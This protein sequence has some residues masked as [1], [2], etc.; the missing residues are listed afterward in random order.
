M[1]SWNPWH[2]CTKISAGCANCYVYRSD[3]NHGRDP[4]AVRKNASFTL[5]V[6]KKRSGAYRLQPDGD[7]V[8]TC[9]TSDFFHPAADEWRKEAWRFMQ[10]RR[11]LEFLIIT[12]RVNRFFV[13]LPE[14]WEEGYENVTV[15]GTCENQE[16]ADFRLPI[17]ASLPIRRKIII[18]EPL[19]GAIDLRRYLAIRE[20]GG[21]PMIRELVCGGE[22][23]NDARI[24]D[25]GWI[26]SLR[27]QCLA[28]GVPF[29]FRQ[30]GAL[31]RKDGRLYR[32]PRRLQHAQAR[33][34][35][36]DTD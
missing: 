28:A 10:I 16:M 14:D 8:Y 19:L 25:Y 9:F 11:D 7:Y 13:S 3:P 4:S 6:D 17:Y 23:G 12:K 15:C 20:K 1:A 32:I 35:G 24:C 26:L 29:R 22:S 18:C 2:G 5:P 36:I 31:F 33:K 30:T 34:A 21:I 27:E